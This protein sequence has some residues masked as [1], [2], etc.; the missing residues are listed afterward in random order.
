MGTCKETADV[1]PPPTMLAGW[2]ESNELTCTFPW[3]VCW[4]RG[5]ESHMWYGWPARNLTYEPLGPP[6]TSS[7]LE[8]G[9]GLK[10]E[11]S[12]SICSVGNGKDL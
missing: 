9:E 12:L 6:Y 2:A 4:V 11:W 10:E 3:W 7:S 5:L 1:S 8:D